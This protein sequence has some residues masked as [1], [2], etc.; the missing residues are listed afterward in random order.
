MKEAG[1]EVRFATPSGKPG[2]AD[3]RLIETGFSILSPIFMTR[4]EVVDLY[5][6]MRRDEHYQEP[7][8]YKEVREEDFDA[9]HV[10]GGHAKGMKLMLESDILQQRIVEF[11]AKDK[12]MGAICHGVL[13]LARSIDPQTGKSVLYGRK[14]TALPRKYELPAWRITSP[15]LNNYYR[16]YPVTVE[17]EVTAS[18]ASEDDFLAG[19]LIHIR[20]TKE[21]PE[22]GFVVRDRNYLSAR[23]PG[24]CYHFG[25][26]FVEL[27]SEQ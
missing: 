17:D 2:D 12:P 6:V 3:S 9:I 16:T 8:T 10:P 7:L 26:E 23:Y 24:D 18:L 25:R 22:R 11:F 13:L 21:N 19:P 1:Y 20:D 5:Q 15:W 4:P 14:T 27:L